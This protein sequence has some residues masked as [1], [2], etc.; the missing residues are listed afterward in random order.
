M[1]ILECHDLITL[2]ITLRDTCADGIR[3]HLDRISRIWHLKREALRKTTT[4]LGN[5]C[6]M[7]LG[8][9][10]WY[11]EIPFEFSCSNQ[12]GLINGFSI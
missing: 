4:C 3:I 6:C 1:R 7:H 11:L 5:I 9:Q 10:A 12:R 2:I 8:S